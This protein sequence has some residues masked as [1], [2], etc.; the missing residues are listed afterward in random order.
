MSLATILSCAN[1]GLQAELVSVEIH[2]SGG[3]PGLTLVGLP[4][5]AVRESRDRVRS[6][7]LN[8]GFEFPTQRITINLSPADLPKDGGRYDLPIALGIL[9]ASGQIPRQAL[10]KRLCI[11]ELSLA[12]AV[13]P[14]KGVLSAG[15]CAQRLGLGLLAPTQNGGEASLAGLE[16]TLVADSLSAVVAYCRRQQPLSGPSPSAA[17]EAPS[18]CDLKDIQGQTL[19]KRALTIAAAGGHSLLMMGPP[20]VGKTL[21]ASAL[22]GLLPPLSPAAQREVTAIHGLL[23]PQ[24]TLHRHP[25]LRQPHHSASTSALIGSCQGHQLRPGEISLAHEG[26]LFLDELPEFNRQALEA[27]RQPL[28]S[29]EIRL[30]RAQLQGTLPARFQLVAAMNPC[31]CGQAGHADHRCRCTPEQL[32]RYRTRLSGPLMDRIDMHLNVAPVALSDATSRRSDA[33]TDSAQVRALVMAAR[34][35]QLQRQGQLNTRL[36]DSGLLQ[37][38]EPDVLQQL[39]SASTRLGLSLRGSHRLLRVARS[40][41]DLAASDRIHGD[42]LA[43]AFSLRAAP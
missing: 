21:L 5:T 20:G 11:G 32:Q 8:G 40:I 36:T 14:V 30:A 6:A 31:P 7:L 1:T 9:M 16:D 27:L 4:A 10:E 15:L 43:E 2:L 28:E 39:A 29:G 26:V 25:P 18:F 33:Q 13:L 41:A 12:G 35:R 17:T 24:L 42:H 37:T 23:Q 3:L 38:L 34:E 22:P 19:A